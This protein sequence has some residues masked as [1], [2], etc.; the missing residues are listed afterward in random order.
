MRKK[1]RIVRK[2]AD[3]SGMVE[4]ED[5]DIP[6]SFDPVDYSLIILRPA[7]DSSVLPREP[8]ALIPIKK[9][10]QIQAFQV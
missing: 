5:G 10:K 2:I 9:P 4:L 6:V 8:D 3:S 7:K 1:Y